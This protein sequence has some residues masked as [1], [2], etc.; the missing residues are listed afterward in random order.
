MSDHL[1]RIDTLANI[2]SS[3]LGVQLEA[4]DLTR[5]DISANLWIF[6]YC[7]GLF[8]A[9]ARYAQLDQYTQGMQMMGAGF[10]QLI[11]DKM[12]GPALF[13]QALDHQ[14][15]AKF[16]EGASFGEAD[17]LAWAADA[18]ALPANLTRYARNSKTQD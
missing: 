11:G 10:G 15:D 4:A 17:L 9:M 3:L 14:D 2:G 12:Q 6:G 7:F 8:E 16:Q 18:N 13:R 1:D 5:A